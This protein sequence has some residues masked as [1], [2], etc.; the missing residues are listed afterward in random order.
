MQF[1]EIINE[2]SPS[3]IEYLFKNTY[4]DPAKHYSDKEQSDL[5]YELNFKL[6]KCYANLRLNKKFD[7]I[8]QAFSDLIFKHHLG[9]SFI[10]C[11][12]SENCQSTR[13]IITNRVK[14]LKKHVL[15]VTSLFSQ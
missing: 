12:Q 7:I 11:I 13:P 14:L 6:Y 15:E 8:S 5:Y 3:G 10:D 2:V 4:L 9:Y 1:M